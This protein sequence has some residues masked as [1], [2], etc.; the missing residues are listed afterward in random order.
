[1]ESDVGRISRRLLSRRLREVP[2]V[3]AAAE[4]EDER[5]R[6][7]QSVAPDVVVEESILEVDA[8]HADDRLAGLLGLDELVTE[9]GACD[10]AS[11]RVR[12]SAVR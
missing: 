1:M 5:R 8:L 11:E 4:L 7:V 2:A 10:P 3:V 12:D 9:E 6:D